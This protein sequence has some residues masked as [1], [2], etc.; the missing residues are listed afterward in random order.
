VLFGSAPQQLGEAVRGVLDAG[1]D[2]IVVEG[3][4]AGVDLDPRAT[5]LD[6]V[7]PRGLVGAVDAVVHHGGA[8]SA[9]ECLRAAVPS[10]GIP[11][12][13]E[14][15]FNVRRLA[16]A[17]VAIL[18]PVAD[19]AMEPLTLREGLVTLAH[20]RQ[21]RLAER[22]AEAVTELLSGASAEAAARAAR[23]VSELPAADV[24]AD[25]VEALGG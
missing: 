17:G 25:A 4:N 11:L 22:T 14:Q 24:A 21:E 15:E 2:A 20:P 19:T 9:I 6:R 3:W 18:V 1:A 10:I 5:L 13:T 7:D 12:Q 16:A 8:G 23:L